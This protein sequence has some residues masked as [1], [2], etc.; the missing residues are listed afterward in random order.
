MNIR[1]KC[2]N[3]QLPSVINQFAFALKNNNI[4]SKVFIELMKND[5]IQPNSI[6]LLILLA[7]TGIDVRF[8]SFSHSRNTVKQCILYL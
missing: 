1:K 6:S 4:L 5:V 3:E 7:L 2:K 8:Y